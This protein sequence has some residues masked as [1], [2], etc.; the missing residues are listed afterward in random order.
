MLFP[1][2]SQQGVNPRVC[3]VP[4]KKHFPGEK[5]DTLTG[6]FLNDTFLKMYFFQKS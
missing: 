6:I 3:H 2:L 5:I 1:S 4:K